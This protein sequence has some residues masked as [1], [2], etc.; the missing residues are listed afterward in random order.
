MTIVTNNAPSDLVITDKQ[1][2]AKKLKEG[3]EDTQNG[4]ACS[5]EDAILEIE[6]ILAN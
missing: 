6:T 4:K 3:I 1:D 2:L 5:L